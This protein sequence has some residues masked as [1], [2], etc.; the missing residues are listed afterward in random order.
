[1][2]PRNRI[3]VITGAGS[4]I[5]A[6][7]ALKYGGLGATTIVCDIDVTSAQKISSQINSLGGN[8]V[9][10][11]IDVTD[12][13]AVIELF[14][15]VKRQHGPVTDLVNNVGIEI[16]GST[17]QFSMENFTRLFDVNVKSCFLCSKVAAAYMIENKCGAIVNLASVAAFKTWP[18]DGVYSATK[19]AVLALTKAFAVD[20]AEYGIRVNAVA[21]AIVDTP[22][23][24]RAIAQDPHPVA[25]RIRREQLH[26]LGRFASPNEIAESIIFL[27]SPKAAFT[28]GTC[29]TIDGGLLA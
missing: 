12:E 28:T 22:M 6:A 20:L 21:P 27:N 16:T 4:G 18:G 29:L 17:H 14:A 11:E 8:A 2:N 25:G 24:E 7:T 10:Y 1:M 15:Y 19:A 26:P 5:G 9:S 13:S 3:A 23:T